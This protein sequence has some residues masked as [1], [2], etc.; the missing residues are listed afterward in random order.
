MNLFYCLL[1]KLPT[2]ESVIMLTRVLLPI[3]IGGRG[4]GG[5]LINEMA[6]LSS[7]TGQVKKFN[8]ALG[9]ILI[10]A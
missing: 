7:L 5:V 3:S 1:I 9:C 4:G 6:S 2:P 10:D 8:F